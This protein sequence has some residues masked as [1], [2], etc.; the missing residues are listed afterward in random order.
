[1]RDIILESTRLL[2]EGVPHV[3]A[4]VV[5]TRGM[6]PQKSGAKLLIREDGSSL[7]TLG[8]GC[9][10]GDMWWYAKEILRDGSG[11]QLRV[12]TLTADLAEK[13][14][15]VCGGTMHFWLEPFRGQAADHS[16]ISEI[17][18][19]RGGG[20]PV[21]LATVVKGNDLLQTGKKILIQD[22][23]RL[24]GTLGSPGLDEELAKV[25]RQLAPNG[26]DRLIETEAGAEIYVE[27][28]TAPPTLIVLGAGHVGKAVC[29]LAPALGFQVVIIDD[30]P[31]FANKKRF[32]EASEI[33]VAEFDKALQQRDVHR[34][35][36]ILIA[37]R[38][39][40]LDDMA[41]LAAVETEA[42]YIGLLGSK[43]KNVLI[44]KSLLKHGVAAARIHEIHAP[45]GLDIGALTP[46]EIAV[47]VMAEIISCIRGGSGESMK[48]DAEL[49]AT[50]AD[51]TD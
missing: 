17:E 20:P 24:Q 33:M 26:E 13:D 8:G 32:P 41:T 46:E 14:G 40:K 47:S 7:G 22:D 19:A 23:G 44:F 16:S 37:T 25:G 39:H 29:S 31:E 9:V 15:L 11:P 36:F 35:S 28:F 50:L 42:R 51:E 10:E 3:V 30:R 1:M 45:V 38:G 34:N 12:Y 43:R 48:M 4:T 18:H 2:R 49:I 6:T 21:A 27:G 5:K